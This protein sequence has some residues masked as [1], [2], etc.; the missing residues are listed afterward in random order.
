MRDNFRYHLTPKT[1]LRS[2]LAWSSHRIAKEP[3]LHRQR[4]FRLLR[5]P[6]GQNRHDL[7]HCCATRVDQG[8]LG[9]QK[10]QKK[11]N[12]PLL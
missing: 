1:C 6:P 3:V 10:E 11:D 2:Q 5:R 8:A 4:T 9:G 7:C 12:T